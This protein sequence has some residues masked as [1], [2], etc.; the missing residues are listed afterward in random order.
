MSTYSTASRRSF[1]ITPAVTVMLLLGAALATWIVT[2]VRMRGMDAGPGTDLGGFGWYVGIWV[3]MMAAMMFPSAAPMVLLFHRVSSEREKR[4]QNFVPTWV[5]ALSYLAVWTT[6]GLAAY[7]LYRLIVHFD[8]GFLDWDRGGRYVAGGAVATAGIYELT[9]LKSV[10]LRHCRSPFHFVMGHWRDGRFGAI[11]MGVEHGAYCVGCCWG[12]MVV[13]FALGV[14]S[15]T[16]MAV[17]AALIL[18]QK[19]LP[20]GE[21]LTKVF[22][23]AFVAVGI[24][25]AS[26]PGSV[27]GL[28]QPN[29]DA[30][31]RARMRMHMS[32]GSEMKPG[33]Q[34]EK[35]AMQSGGG[36]PTDSPMKPTRMKPKP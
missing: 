33:T 18:A 30:A 29:S 34:M 31:D 20:R 5:F 12:L 16:W 6:Y 32:P 19:V 13:L 14:M 1:R 35:P 28:T 24:W 2:V 17:V 26:A 9:P 11:R 27:P 22:A 36:A 23:V 8:F 21:Q 15:L 10:C 7:G 3:T 25:V 4:G